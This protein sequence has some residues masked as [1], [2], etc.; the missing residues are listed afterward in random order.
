MASGHNEVTLFLPFVM[1]LQMLLFVHQA[2]SKGLPDMQPP[3]AEELI[4]AHIKEL[5]EENLFKSPVRKT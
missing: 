5:T 4:D 1:I 3:E 2:K